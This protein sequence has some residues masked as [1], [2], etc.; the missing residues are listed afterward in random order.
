MNKDKGN[1]VRIGSIPYSDLTMLSARDLNWSDEKFQSLDINLAV[2]TGE[3]SDLN[4][5]DIL[6]KVTICLNI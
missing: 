1:T 3:I 2:E 6:D 5:P 4:H